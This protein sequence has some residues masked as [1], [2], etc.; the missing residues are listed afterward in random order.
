VREAIRACEIPYLALSHEC[1]ASPA[2]RQ[3]SVDLVFKKRAM[4][5]ILGRRVRNDE[6]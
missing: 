5:V 6:Q 2:N 4:N 3:P 1:D